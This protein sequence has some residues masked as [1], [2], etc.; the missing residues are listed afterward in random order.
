MSWLTTRTAIVAA[1]NTAIPALNTCQAHGGRFTL[2]DLRRYSL[3]S[4][5]VLVSL[6]GGT[7][8]IEAGTTVTPR[9]WVVFVI[10]RGESDDKRDAQAIA[11]AQTV[12]GLIPNNRWSDDNNHAPADVTDDNLY[13]VTL[14][15][16][17]VA[18]W[19]VSW[20]QGYDIEPDSS[21]LDDFVTLYGDWDNVP[22]DTEQ[23]YSITTL[24]Q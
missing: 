16:H 4:P 8:R 21:S 7:T 12:C 6:L 9:R 19:A 23:M 5:A 14:D 20:E 24:E 18:L 10:T 11:I 13:N 17:G 3:R 2:E 15:K 1:I 22:E